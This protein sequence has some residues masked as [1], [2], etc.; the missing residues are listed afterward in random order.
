MGCES[1]AHEAEGRMG[2]W[3]RGH[4]GERNNYFG[5][6]RSKGFARLRNV[7]KLSFLDKTGHLKSVGFRFYSSLWR[8]ESRISS[9]YLEITSIS[10]IYSLTF[11]RKKELYFGFPGVWTDSPM[12]PVRSEQTLSWGISRL[13]YCDPRTQDWACKF[14]TFRLVSAISRNETWLLRHILRSLR[15]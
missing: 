2:Y 5:G 3:L 8:S 13:P 10:L 14:V 9:R 6:A 7:S 1:I 15:V 4:E 12:W 11:F